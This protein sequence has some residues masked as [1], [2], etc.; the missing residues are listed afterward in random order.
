MRRWRRWS[1]AWPGLQGHGRGD[2]GVDPSRSTSAVAAQ[3]HHAGTTGAGKSELLQTFVAS[4][5]VTH[6][7]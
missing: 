3:P 1:G 6:P 7:P 4:L 5:A 2:R